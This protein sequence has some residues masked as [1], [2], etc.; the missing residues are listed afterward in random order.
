MAIRAFAFALV[1]TLLIAVVGAQSP[2]TVWYCNTQKIPTGSPFY[3][4]LSCL[5]ADLVQHTVPS[6]YGYE[7]S[8]D[9]D[10]GGTAYGQSQCDRSLSQSECTNCLD[11]AWIN[12]AIVCNDAIGAQFVYVNQCDVH[13]EQYSF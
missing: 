8:C 4:S 2:N 10:N 6:L 5:F 9:A 12:A 13:Y 7:T 3:K 1:A 11:N